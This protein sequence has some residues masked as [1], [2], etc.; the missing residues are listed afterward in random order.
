M[1]K[2][3]KI[4][5]FLYWVC[6]NKDS[7][8]FNIVHPVVSLNIARK[9]KQLPRTTKVSYTFTKDYQE[10][11]KVNCAF[12]CVISINLQA[13]SHR[14]CHYLSSWVTRTFNHFFQCSNK[15]QEIWIILGPWTVKL[16]VHQRDQLIFVFFFVVFF[17]FYPLIASYHGG[18]WQS[19]RFCNW[20]EKP[21]DLSCDL[22]QMYQ[23]PAY[24][25]M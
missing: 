25:I 19:L 14:V 6:I 24:I 18:S 9:L 2:T 22:Q 5:H 7:F 17:L 11:I 3:L 1:K 23:Q 8:D 12:S 10:P 20:R 4:E 21:C 13:L 15:L 16:Y